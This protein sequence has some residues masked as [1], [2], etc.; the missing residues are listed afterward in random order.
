MHISRRCA[1]LVRVVALLHAV[2]TP[3]ATALMTAVAARAFAHHLPGLCFTAQPRIV[4]SWL[5]RRERPA[6]PCAGIHMQERDPRRRRMLRIGELRREI[7]LDVQQKVTK[8]TV[9]L[10]CTYIMITKRILRVFGLFVC[11]FGSVC[12]CMCV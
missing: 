7:A 6:Q 2:V 3:G 12:V 9:Y 8:N 4:H 10:G 11:L 1:L 5:S